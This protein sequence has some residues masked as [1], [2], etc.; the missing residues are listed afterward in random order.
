GNP[1]DEK[2]DLGPL[3]R[4]DLRDLLDRQVKESLRKGAKLLVGGEIPA[5]NGAFY[6]PTIL[7]DVQKGMPAYDEEIFGPVAAIIA[8]KNERE[9]VRLAND[10]SYGLGSGIFSRNL[11]KAQ[12]LAR[13]DLQAGATFV[14]SFVQSDPRLPFGGIKESGFGRELGVFGIHEFVNIKTV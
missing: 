3:A 5:G 6:P 12:K 7:T 9:A 2:S 14:N 8:A 13:E 10:T 4:F 1:M 11:R